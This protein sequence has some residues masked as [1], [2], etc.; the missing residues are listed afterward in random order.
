ML[1][2]PGGRHIHTQHSPHVWQL[3]RQHE[4]DYLQKFEFMHLTQETKIVLQR[5]P[6]VLTFR[7]FPQSTTYRRLI[8]TNMAPLTAKQLV[9]HA[10]S[11]LGSHH[12]F[13]VAGDSR[14]DRSRNPLAAPRVLDDF[15]RPL[16]QKD[17]EKANRRETESDDLILQLYGK[18]ALLT[19]DELLGN[20]LEGQPQIDEECDR[21]FLEEVL[22]GC[23]RY[24][25]VIQPA[26][27][28]AYRASNRLLLKSDLPLY[29]VLSYLC[30][31]RLDE[32]TWPEMKRLF[33]AAAGPDPRNMACFVRVLFD[34]ESLQQGGVLYTRWAKLLDT[35]WVEDNV[36]AGLRR[37]LD[38]GIGLADEMKT[39]ADMGMVIV[40][41]EPKKTEPQPFNITQHQNTPRNPPHAPF[42][43]PHK[44]LPVP[45]TLYE[46]PSE[47]TRLDSLR[48]QNRHLAQQKLAAA[49]MHAP[50][51]ATYTR[52]PAPT[53]PTEATP[54]KPTIRAKPPPPTLRAPPPHP[55]KPTAA[56]ILRDR[57]VLLHRT[58]RPFDAAA[59]T[60]DH[61]VGLISDGE[62]DAWRDARRREEAELAALERERRRLEVVLA[63]E[64]GADRKLDV[65]RENREK[66]AVVHAEAVVLKKA[67]EEE[68][69]REM[70]EN[71][72]KREE[73]VEGR[74]NVRKAIEKVREE[75][76]KT[77][78]ELEA[79]R[80]ALI[81]SAKEAAEAE[82]AA[83]A[84][85]IREI[86]ALERE[87]PAV[88]TTR[89][90]VDVDER[91][92]VGLLSEMSVAELTARLHCARQ[93]EAARAE[94]RRSEIAAARLTKASLLSEVQEA[95]EKER[96]EL[97][98]KREQEA[99]VKAEREAKLG[100]E[101]VG[102]DVVREVEEMRR[103]VDEKK[104]ARMAARALERSQMLALVSKPSSRASS[105]AGTRMT[106]RSPSKMVTRSPSRM[107]LGS[108]M[109]VGKQESMEAMREVQSD[110]HGCQAMPPGV[111]K[112]LRRG[113]SSMSSEPT[114]APTSTKPTP[115][116]SKPASAGMRKAISAGKQV[117]Q[118]L[119]S[120]SGSRIGSARVAASSR[121]KETVEVAAENTEGI[122]AGVGVGQDPGTIAE[123]PEDRVTEP[124]M[125]ELSKS[126]LQDSKAVEPPTAET[127]S[128]ESRPRSAE[129]E[130]KDPAAAVEECTP[131]L[132]PRPLSS[133]S[134]PHTAASC[135]NESVKGIA[136]TGAEGSG[137]REEEHA[138]DQ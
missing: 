68:E 112:G 130:T 76:A 78:S 121:M 118:A 66:A 81:Q 44:P 111:E 38:S 60:H 9:H 91:S 64:N 137:V 50:K 37:H 6:C 122:K 18:P 133:K 116:S 2:S 104:R 70:E 105:I 74:E 113:Y 39:R 52:R 47:R 45:S 67:Q 90:E 96:E 128:S 110:S 3:T 135:R 24:S 102:G 31:M 101:G 55:I 8:S 7:G 28:T 54:P 132:V 62:Y 109:G 136:G 88:G 107:G 34:N 33:W 117:H 108:A 4:K 46:P 124:L 21:I 84:Q 1:L 119:R 72:R 80:A 87:V 23:A 100:V 138:A 53:G 106:T 115:V 10:A 19:E 32:I 123:L 56:T 131:V 12:L 20:Y 75:N 97:R 92:G 77:V 114:E 99:K 93:K 17:I 83:K 27:E 69:E 36:I 125:K 11:L 57:A 58:I 127:A 26:L 63:R 48:T 41:S 61:A 82:L 51:V 120:G 43:K 126:S 29:A 73:V 85:L 95:V 5:K 16:F 15:G 86:R 42:L 134:R 40:K 65:V 94:Q 79:Q 25:R 22:K 59:V 71:R 103:I 30:L 129:V 98:R 35:A 49:A 14:V 89:R 13:A